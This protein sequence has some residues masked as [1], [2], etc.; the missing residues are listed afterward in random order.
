[1]PY[2]LKSHIRFAK[3]GKDIIFLDLE[4][5]RYSALPTSLV[6]AFLKLT[7][8]DESDESN[9]NQLTEMRLLNNAVG[10][11]PRKFICDPPA[12]ESSISGDI[13]QMRC[14]DAVEAL[15]A[16]IAAG[17]A[18]RQK[19]LADIVVS[20]E[21]A[22]ANLRH[23]SNGIDDARAVAAAFALTNRIIE[24]TDQCFAISIALFRTLVRRGISASLVIG[25]KTG[26]F[27]AHCWVQV[28][29]IIINDDRDLV[30]NFVPI[31]EI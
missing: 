2:S 21:R 9:V 7:T 3:Y 24:R 17:I 29:S 13:S 11:L 5:N 22:K 19:R 25:V 6:P 20:L 28:G 23:K 14:F 30:A 16:R 12:I 26:P 4:H 27:S 8:G 1:M 31:L 10:P 15:M 18:I